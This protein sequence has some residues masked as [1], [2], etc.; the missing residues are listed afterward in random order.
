MLN[1]FRRVIFFLCVKNKN[2]NSAKLVCYICQVSHKLYL[3]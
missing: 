1:K 2:D 3:Y